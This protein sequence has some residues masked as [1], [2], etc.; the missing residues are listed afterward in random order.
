MLATKPAQMDMR[1]LPPWTWADLKE[2]LLDL[3]PTPTHQ[4]MVEH[5]VEGL[6]LSA[7]FLTPPGVLR[8]LAIITLAMTDSSS[9]TPPTQEAA[10]T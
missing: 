3:A 8:E 10:V 9:P 5:L 1:I 7:P 4:A 2:V 6:R